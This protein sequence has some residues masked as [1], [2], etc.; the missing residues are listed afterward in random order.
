MIKTNGTLTDVRTLFYLSSLLLFIT[1]LCLLVDSF[2]FV[3][4]FCAV[5]SVCCTVKHSP[6]SSHF[7]YN[8]N[9]T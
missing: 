2:S 6:V 1:S 3:I 5:C 4:L 7:L 9:G 8:M